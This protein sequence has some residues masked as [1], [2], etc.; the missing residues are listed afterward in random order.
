M[1]QTLGSIA[2]LVRRVGIEGIS[3]SLKSV[4][5]QNSL[6]PLV[7]FTIVCVTDVT[8]TWKWTAAQYGKHTVRPSMDKGRQ[9]IPMSRVTDTECVSYKCCESHLLA[10]LTKIKKGIHRGLKYDMCSSVCVC[11]IYIYIYSACI[12][13]IVLQTLNLWGG[14][15]RNG[16]LLRAACDFIGWEAGPP[17]LTVLVLVWVHAM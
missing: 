9:F 17:Y 3:V 10:K 16:P 1:L 5:V 13:E 12:Q 8:C 6:P 11:T 2:Q 4:E 15:C 7:C 14:P